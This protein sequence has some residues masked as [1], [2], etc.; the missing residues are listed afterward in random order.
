VHCSISCYLFLKL[1]LTKFIDDLLN[2]YNNIKNKQNT[3]KN[4]A[5]TYA[6]H[7]RR[8]EQI[9]TH[10]MDVGFLTAL[11]RYLFL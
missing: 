1:H 2:S 11:H 6:R 4:R 3:R 5:L 9:A 8:V 10:T 7:G